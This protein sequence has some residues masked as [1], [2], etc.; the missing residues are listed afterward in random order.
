M[1]RFQ[2]IKLG[3]LPTSQVTLFARKNKIWQEAFSGWASTKQPYCA[4]LRHMMV[5]KTLDKNRGAKKFT[6]STWTYVHGPRATARAVE[7][8]KISPPVRTVMLDIIQK[9]RLQVLYQAREARVFCLLAGGSQKWRFTEM[10]SA[11]SAQNARSVFSEEMDRSHTQ[12]CILGHQRTL[13]HARCTSR[14]ILPFD[15]EKNKNFGH[16]L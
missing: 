8:R 14:V 10:R 1:D 4:V 7:M 15:P 12:S 5:T 6:R 13:R 3:P 16:S 9:K 2:N 11:G